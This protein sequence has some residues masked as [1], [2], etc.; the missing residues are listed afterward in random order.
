MITGKNLIGQKLSAKGQK[1][2]TTFNPKFN[3]ANAWIFYEATKAEVDLA[4][5]LAWDAFTDF[6]LVSGNENR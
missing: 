1:T 6:Q 3:S 2:F 5:R 4:A